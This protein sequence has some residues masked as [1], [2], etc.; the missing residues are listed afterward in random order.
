MAK[1]TYKLANNFDYLHTQSGQK[2]YSFH[3][4]LVCASVLHFCRRF[5]CVKQRERKREW[6]RVIGQSMGQLERLI[7]HIYEKSLSMLRVLK[8]A[9]FFCLHRLRERV[10]W[11]S[12]W[13]NER[14]SEWSSEWFREYVW[15]L[16]HSPIGPVYVGWWHLFAIISEEVNEER[17]M[18]NNTTRNVLNCGAFNCVFANGTK[19]A[20]VYTTHK[21]I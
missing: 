19:W 21:Q 2:A 9:F 18:Y 3:L 15:F 7:F 8:K 5:V 20:F 16:W 11:S 17:T 1:G 12:E 6:V 4:I 14:A 10:E 13:A